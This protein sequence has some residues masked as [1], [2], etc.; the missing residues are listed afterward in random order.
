MIQLYKMAWRD[1]GRN[2]RRTFFSMLALAFGVALLVFMDSFIAGEMRD[3]LQLAIKLQSGHL[4]VRTATYNEDKTSLKWEDLIENPDAV[5]ARIAARPE[6]QVATPRLYATGIVVA[7]DTSAGVRVVGI[8]PDSAASAPFS[9][10]MTSGSYLTA[11]DRG[12]LLMGRT[13]A[14]KL[15][16]SSGDKVNLLVNTS[17]GDVDQQ[18]FVIR[19]LFSTGT[20]GYDQN[21]IFLPLSKAQAIARADNRASIILI[22][23]KDQDQTDALAAALQEPAYQIKTYNQMNPLLNEFEQ[24]ANAMMYVFYLIVLGIT[25]TVI[26]N[27]LVMSVFERTREIGILSAM[28]MRGGRIMAM[29]FAES[30]LLA[31]GGITMGVALGSLISAFVQRYGIFIGDF[32]VTGIFIG[33]RIYTYLTLKDIITLAIMAFVITLLSAIYPAMVAARLEPVEALHGGK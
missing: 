31:V 19:G 30:S 3:A 11:D 13:L 10:G 6:V 22:L 5:A 7:G 17:N 24:Y 15:K 2:R 8:D 21:T 32:G 1:L 20:P 23:L 28:G 4:Q 12:G 33:E 29:F 16:L 27:T 25:A 14:D 18:P 9:E 26:V